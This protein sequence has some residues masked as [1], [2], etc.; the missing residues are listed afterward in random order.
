MRLS[1]V[2]FCTLFSITVKA[3]SD[4]EWLVDLPSY[5]DKAIKSNSQ[6]KLYCNAVEETLS[7]TNQNP[8]QSCLEQICG[9][10]ETFTSALDLWTKDYIELSGKD[11]SWKDTKSKD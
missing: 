2:L 7:K 1:L 10:P 8:Y 6:E 4:L 3:T 9:D 11:P 5:I